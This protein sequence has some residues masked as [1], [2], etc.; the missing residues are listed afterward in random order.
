LA[1]GGG[2]LRMAT[3]AVSIDVD[4]ILINLANLAQAVAVDHV[5]AE[6][7]TRNI[8]DMLA[9]LND[10]GKKAAILLFS[11]LIEQYAARAAAYA[12]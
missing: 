3:P 12:R 7:G 4:Q 9:S 1:D 2:E 5:T 11:R 6:A 8:N 10:E